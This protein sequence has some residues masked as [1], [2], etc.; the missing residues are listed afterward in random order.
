MKRNSKPTKAKSR[1]QAK[2]PASQSADRAAL[3]HARALIAER[4]TMKP[5]TALRKAG[6]AS[7]RKIER[8]SEVLSERPAAPRLRKENT[9]AASTSSPIVPP[10]GDRLQVV[11]QDEF[12]KRIQTAMRGVPGFPLPTPTGVWPSTGNVMSKGAPLSPWAKMF[13]WSPY[14]L[15]LWQAAFVTDF[16]SR[17]TTRLGSNDRALRVA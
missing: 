5:A 12:A 1:T 14:G 13:R 7:A 15:M 17:A 16:F 10:S 3:S 8:L 9:K 11:D 2:K 6:V 4:P